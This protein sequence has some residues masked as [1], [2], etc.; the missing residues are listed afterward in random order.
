MHQPLTAPLAKS[1]AAE[2]SAASND[3]VPYYE[4]IM[5][6]EPEVLIRSFAD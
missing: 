3:A 5:A 2:E 4:G 6:E 1:L